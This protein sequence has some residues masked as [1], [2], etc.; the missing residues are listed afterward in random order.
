MQKKK[1]VIIGGGPSGMMSAIACAKKNPQFEVIILEK[2]SKLGTKLLIS[3][4]GRCNV[5][6]SGDNQHIIDNVIGNGKFLYSAL[7]QFSSIDIINFFEKNGCKLKEEDRGRMF[8][9]SD[10]SI[11]ILKTLM[12]E[13]TRLNVKVW[14]NCAVKDVIIKDDKLVGV[15]TF[16]NQNVYADHFVFALGGKSYK[17]VG[18]TGDGYAFLTKLNHSIT[19]LYPCE[20]PLVSNEDFIQDKI[21]MGLSFPDVELSIY[22]S[23]NKKFVTINNDILFTHFGISGPGA[24]RCSS[25][26]QK[27][28]NKEKFATMKINFFPNFTKDE[29]TSKLLNLINEHPDKLA[30]NI[31]SLLLNKKVITYMFAKLNIKETIKAKELKRTIN[32]LI[33]LMCSFELKIHTTLGFDKAFVTGGGVKIKEIDPKTMKSKLHD[34]ISICGELIDIN[35]YTGGY[36]ITAALSTGFCSGNNI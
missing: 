15:K 21:F 34:N 28:M 26:V 7:N 35:A 11:D 16:D 24:L 29:L 30:I 23:K 10:R 33:N 3:G 14:N 13:L 19:K 2:K 12:N 32:E 17:E 4:G 22:N 8:P 1:I 31:A 20:V 6:N 25:F 36:N 5:T 9:K 18:T 27:V